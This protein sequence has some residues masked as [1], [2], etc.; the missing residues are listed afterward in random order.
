MQKNGSKE[1]LGGNFEPGSP[2]QWDN[3]CC[4]HGPE[5]WNV[6]PVAMMMN[7]PVI[8]QMKEKHVDIGNYGTAQSRPP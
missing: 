6:N 4:D 1:Q 2:K 5:K 3:R 8:N 7:G